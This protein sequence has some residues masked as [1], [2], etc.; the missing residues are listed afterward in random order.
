MKAELQIEQQTYPSGKHYIRIRFGYEH[1]GSYDIVEG[2]FLVFGCRKPVA[3]ER[4]AQI[5]AVKQ[6]VQKHT[7]LAA[8]ASELLE[9]I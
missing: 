3:T 8:K 5:K 2:G 4:E 7:K 6:Y 9:R 1:I